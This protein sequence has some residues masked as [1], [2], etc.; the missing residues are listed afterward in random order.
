[1]NGKPE[2]DNL[3]IG[4]SRVIQDLR[5]SIA[6][7]APTDLSVLITGES[8]TGKELI[9]RLIHENSSRQKGPLVFIDVAALVPTLAASD[10]L[11][12]V[13][14]AF[15]GASHDRTGSLETARG[16]TIYLDEVE[17]IPT[18]IQRLFIRAMD[19]GTI[20]RVGAEKEVPVDFRV[21]AAATTELS[22][23]A[24]NGILSQ[25]FLNRIASFVIRVPPLRERLEDVPE[26]AHYFLDRFKET[27]RPK[28]RISKE[29]LAVLANYNF[30]GNIRELVNHIQR[31]SI[32]CKGGTIQVEDLSLDVKRSYPIG[33]QTIRR[34][35]DTAQSQLKALRETTIPATPIWEG[36]FFPTE[37]DYC[38]VLMPLSDTADVQRVYSDHVKPVIEGRCALRCE[39]ADDIYDVSGVM[40]SVW[41]G[42]NRARL[43]IADL[44]ER[45]PNVFY[46][47]GI[48]HTLGKPVIMLTQS[49]EFVPFDLRH[50]RCIVYEFKPKDIERLEVALERTVKT[51]LSGTGPEP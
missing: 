17:Q 28:V 12:Y 45:N 8:G 36:R 44:T 14:G 5:K 2:T 47:L 26:L 41:E 40:Q 37:Q 21:I 24:A 11:G 35:L 43:V 23:L 27:G 19:K 33:A 32:L 10:L 7:V 31:A 22:E 48:A 51:I 15:T 25:D 20:R 3:L 39:R 49:M 16:G 29:A 18:E 13:K 6:V 46:E 4:Q 50:L 9:S 34:E 30:P 38:F 1:M 42:I